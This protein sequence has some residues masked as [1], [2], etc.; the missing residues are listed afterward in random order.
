MDKSA[1]G[2]EALG[3]RMNFSYLVGAYLAVNAIRDCRIVVDG[4]DCAF[5]KGQFIAGRHDLFSTLYPATGPSRI[6]YTGTDT[7]TVMWDRE[8]E[9]AA[10]AAG[11][12]GI[13]PSGIVLVTGLP[14]GAVVGTHYEKI[15]AGLKSPRASLAVL[16]PRSLQ[17]DWMDGYAD[18]LLAAARS[19]RLPKARTSKDKV[20]LVGY[21]LD[22][23]EGDHTGNLGE[24]KAMLAGLSLELVS[25]WP[26]G[27][28]CDDLRKASRAGT[29]LSLPYGRE[30][31]RALAARTGAA[32]VE[33]DLPF[34]IEGTRRWI[35]QVA[36]RAGRRTQARHEGLSSIMPWIERAVP[37]FLVGRRVVLVADPRMTA[38]FLE[39]L[40]ELGMRPGTVVVAGRKEHLPGGL[41]IARGCGAR[42]LFE[43]SH[44]TFID[45]LRSGKSAA[46]LVICNGEIARSLRGHLPVVEFGFP[47][48][49]WHVLTERAFLGF[50]GAL[51]FV[52]RMVNALADPARWSQ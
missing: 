17:G 34:G 30:A 6:V 21:F 26:G 7:H 46:D 33:T 13:V 3:Q 43:P 31:A 50:R 40:C 16:P 37:G 4:P 41:A 18:A 29:I 19:M 25:V 14:M 10:A 52:E 35:E 23:T 36:S 1:A 2:M 49:A 44:L 39:F 5:F 28:P 9:I 15:V 22:R 32:L 38:P 48:P 11:A 12:V 42:V 24:L 27:G 20:A 51:G 47:S 45:A 8:K